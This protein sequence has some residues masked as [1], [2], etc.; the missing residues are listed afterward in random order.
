MGI[1]LNPNNTAFKKSRT[2]K[3]YVDKSLLIAAMNAL[4]GT[5]QRFVCVSRPRRFGKSMAANMLSAYYSRGCDS[6]DLFKGLAIEKDE[7]YK[8]HLNQHNVIRLDIQEFLFQKSHLDIFIEEIQKAVIE[9]LQAEYRNCFV[10]NPYGL[11]D[12]LRR[13]YKSTGE[14]FIFIIDEWDCVF[15]MAKENKEIQKA[16]LDFLRGLFKGQDYVDLAYMTGILPIKKY[17]EHSAVNIFDEFSMIDPAE[18]ASFFGFTEEEVCELC[19]QKGIDFVELQKWY[20]GYVLDGIHIY[21]PKSVVDVMRHR[22]FRSYWTGTETYEALK[23]YIDLN[24]DGLKEAVISMLGNVPC[25]INTRKFQ[26]DM[27]TFKTKDDVL[28]LLV[29]LGYLAYNETDAKVMIPNQEIAE[30]FLNAVEEPDWNGL[31]QSL[32]RSENLLKSTWELNGN[33][34]AAGMTAIHSETASILKYND[35]NSLTC[36]VLMAYYSAKTY[37]LNPVMELPSGK[38]FADVVYLPKRNV[39]RPALVVELKWNKSAEGAIAQIKEKQYA[40]WIEN[41]TGNILLVGIS[42]DEKKGHQCV[43]ETYRK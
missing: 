32:E 20:D 28:T 29:H 42:Y 12:A 25:K 14:G 33:A 26:N 6:A 35:E 19:D 30:E 40:S 5:E 7:T 2:S 4:C 38:G 21:N 39:D 41:Y 1:Y 13:V 17:G 11:P 15:R 34:V 18:L 8:K 37:Y 16:Y 36:T 27:T 9:D 10:Q 23:I 43:I 31:I 3:I 22:K 24:F